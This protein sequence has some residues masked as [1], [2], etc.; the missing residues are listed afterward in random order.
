MKGGNASKVENVNAVLHSNL[1]TKCVKISTAIVGKLPYKTAP[2]YLSEG[3][4]S[5]QALCMSLGE[6]RQEFDQH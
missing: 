3:P 4:F 6:R 5:A 2:E 1:K